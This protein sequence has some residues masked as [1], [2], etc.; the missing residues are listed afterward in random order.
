MRPGFNTWYVVGWLILFF[1]IMVFVIYM[2]R[3]YDYRY[4]NSKK[5]LPTAAMA[6]EKNTFFVDM[7]KQGMFETTKP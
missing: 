6:D 1:L 2:N 7:G 3:I 4:N 5:S